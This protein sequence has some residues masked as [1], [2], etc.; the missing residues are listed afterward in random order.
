MCML[1]YSGISKCSRITGKFFIL[2][3][4]SPEC[5]SEIADSGLNHFKV[6][7]KS[8][9][10]FSQCNVFS[11]PAKCGYCLPLRCSEIT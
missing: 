7:T 4:F 8:K 10:S 1:S 9:K 11:I 6:K 3:P 5:E 2:Y